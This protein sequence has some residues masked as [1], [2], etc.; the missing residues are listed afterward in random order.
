[1]TIFL[2]ITPIHIIIAVAI[3]FVA[4]NKNKKKT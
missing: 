3:D 1:M 2:N 4:R